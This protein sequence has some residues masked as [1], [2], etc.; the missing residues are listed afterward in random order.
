[1]VPPDRIQVV[2]V[3]NSPKVSQTF[4]EI[5]T[6]F[7]EGQS[8]GT[9][10]FVATRTGT[11]HLEAR[12]R[13]AR[14]QV[15]T[16]TQNDQTSV[17]QPDF[18]SLVPSISRT[19]QGQSSNSQIPV[20]T[21]V[22][23]EPSPTTS[24]KKPVQDTSLIAGVISG[25]VVFIMLVTIGLLLNH[26]RKRRLLRVMV[27]PVSPYPDTTSAMVVPGEKKR[28]LIGEDHDNHHVLDTPPVQE[29]EKHG[30]EPDDNILLED[31]QHQT[32]DPLQQQGRER[33]VRYHDDSG[34]RP[35]PPFSDAGE[36][37]VLDVPP[38][39]DAAV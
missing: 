18:E 7:V 23:P 32:Q 26:R 1:M 37:S 20:T 8:R 25:T 16:T 10:A 28:R 30:D 3:Q 15:S 19:N 33:R 5:Q 38:Q 35:A 6:K 11:F 13:L 21:T 31:G 17:Y 14:E 22:T 34:W 24:P 9:I 39:Y 36:S 4:T 27:P 2:L 12:I 29:P